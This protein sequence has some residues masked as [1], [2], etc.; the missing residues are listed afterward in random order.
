MLDTEELSLNESNGTL[1]KKH[2]ST[3]VNTYKETFGGLT[4]KVDNEREEFDF[5]VGNSDDEFANVKAKEYLTP[6]SIRYKYLLHS[7]QNENADKTYLTEYSAKDKT[8]KFDEPMNEALQAI[9]ELPLATFQYN[10]NFKNDYDKDSYFKR[11]FGIIVEQ[12]ANT[13]KKFKTEE[14]IKNATS[15]DNVEY[16]YTADEKESISEYLKLLTDDKEVSLNTNNAI[17]ILLKAAKETQE[18]LLNLEV[19]TYGKDS[20]TLPGADEKNENFKAN[21]QKSTV[22]GLNRL[23]KALCREVFQDA[24]PS[25]IDGKGAWSEDSENYSR[26]DML[27]K[28][29]N[30]ENA[31]DDDGQSTR[32]QLAD[33]TTYPVDA[34]VTQTVTTISRDFVKDA[35]NDDDFDTAQEFIN[36][37]NYSEV[38]GTS[39]KFDGLNDAVNRIVAKL[40]TL[41]ILQDYRR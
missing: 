17:G 8:S 4:I 6:S 20:P 35:D 31:K 25:N 9:Y 14:A 22:A 7:Y 21:D 34:S 29:I 32:I 39:D 36:E 18:R 38:D 1:T 27:D 12:T 41:T 11:F 33:V 40:N 2:T 30:G 23:V 16:T 28:E 10:R 37:V 24:D 26:L 5:L 3:K 13:S 15:V 19:S